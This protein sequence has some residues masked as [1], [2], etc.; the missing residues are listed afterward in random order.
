MD[1]STKA[2]DVVKE[3]YKYKRSGNPSLFIKEVCR[4]FDIVKNS[5]LSPNDVVFLLFLANEAGVPQ[6]YDMLKSKYGVSDVPEENINL[7]TLSAYIHDSSLFVNHC[8]LHRYQKEV[9]DC[10]IMDRQNR[11]VLTAPTSFGKTYVVYEIMDKLNY[12]RN[13]PFLRHRLGYFTELLA[14]EGITCQMRNR[15]I[16]CNYGVIIL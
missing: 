10:F 8:K 16:W 9:L 15:C 7:L 6:Y 4:Y 11:F 1:R 13:S 12:N 3:L 2:V 14:F 5:A